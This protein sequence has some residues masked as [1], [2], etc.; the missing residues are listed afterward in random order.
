VM[1]LLKDFNL[2]PDEIVANDQSALQ[3][4]RAYK[5]QLLYL[6][7]TLEENG[8]F[9]EASQLCLPFLKPFQAARLDI[10]SSMLHMHCNRLGCDRETE[11]SVCQYAKE[12][13]L[14]LRYLTV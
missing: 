10:Y 5:S 12:I 8:P 7:K 11:R 6:A 14:Q 1:A 13:L 3:G 9:L 4:F 2:E